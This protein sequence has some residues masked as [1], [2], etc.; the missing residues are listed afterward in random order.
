MVWSRPASPRESPQPARPVS[1]IVPRSRQESIAWGKPPAAA[2]V[3]VPSRRRRERPR[4]DLLGKFLAEASAETSMRTYQRI[5]PFYDGLDPIYAWMWKRPRRRRLLRRARGRVLDVGIGTGC[6]LPHYPAEV[7]FVGID[8][9]QRMMRG[10]SSASRRPATGVATVVQERFGGRVGARIG[11]ATPSGARP[12][13][14][15][16]ARR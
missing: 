15:W 4:S 10:P 12:V 5:A 13:N 9:S 3:H 6:N 16:R 8:L 7:E 2:S 11:I 1:A 14:C